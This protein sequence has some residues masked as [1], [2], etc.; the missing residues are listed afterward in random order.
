LIGL[1]GLL[2]GIRRATAQ[3]ETDVL[4]STRFGMHVLETG[5]FYRVDTFSW[6]ATGKAWI[7]NS[8]AWDVVLGGAY[9]A[10][11]MVGIWIA[12]L[13]VAL[14]CVLVVAR[15]AASVGARPY[16][17]AI[18]VSI[19]A[20]ATLVNLPR[21]AA[22]SNMLILVPLLLVSPVLFGTR[23]EAVRAG[24]LLACFEAIWMNLH[25]EATLGVVLF[26]AAGIATVFGGRLR[27]SLL[28]DAVARLIAVC[29]V[30][31]LACLAT[32]YGLSGI[33]HATAV[34]RASVGLI[35]EWATPG[36][37]SPGREFGL[38]L[39]VLAVPMAWHAWRGRRFGFAAA[40]LVMGALTCSAIRFSTGMTIILAPELALLLGSLKVRDKI[41]RIAVA[42]SAAILAGIA[43]TNL[44]SFAK[45]SD[46]DGSPRLVA[47]LPAGCRVLNDYTLGGQI[48]LARP[49]VKVAIDGRN[50][51]YGRRL[52]TTTSDWLYN[53]PDAIPTLDANGVRC[54]LAPT[55]APIV[56]KLVTLPQWRV[57]GHDSYRTLVVRYAASTP[58][59]VGASR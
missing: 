38:L 28:R 5:H 18:V 47:Q 7:A 13:A 26:A 42:A 39:V 50:D 2:L 20:V 59:P 25:S 4:W 33:T 29:T 57:L 15:V 11:G 10:G 17:T 54:V 31:A 56:E 14:G 52:V 58:T 46:V 49:D 24:A 45:L 55:H 48:I 30:M 1:L 34:R 36:L 53:P 43:V 9:E 32:P 19:T 6:T 37:G 27:G 23:R 21:A 12:G 44:S 51:M 8:W 16:P 22:V 35:A 40:I 3:M 41:F